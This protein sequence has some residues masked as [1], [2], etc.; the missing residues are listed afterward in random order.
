MGKELI[1]DQD[2]KSPIAEIFRTLRTNLQFMT[3]NQGLKTLLI[4]SGLP[5]EGKSWVSAN[6]AIAFAGEGKKVALIDSDMR[7]GRLHTIFE[8][9]RKPGLSNFLSGISE[10]KQKDDISDYFK[11]T[12]I[13]NLFIMP[14]GDAVPNPSELLVSNKMTE[15]ITRLK[16]NFDI[17]IFDGTPILLV[18]DSLILARQLD[19]SLIVTS[20]K[21]TKM[22]DIEK[23]KKMIENVRGKIAG[24][25]I[26]KIP[27]TIKKYENTYYYGHHE[28]T[29]KQQKDNKIIKDQTEQNT[30][31]VEQVIQKEIKEFM[32]KQENSKDNLLEDEEQRLEDD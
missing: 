2:P 32:Q 19:S 10:L 12:M 11:K 14:A 23:I 28:E 21:T 26:N 9:D 16:N 6:L 30:V 31:D 1:I 25:V 3:S 29:K 22:G 5:G 20:Y 13:E 7:K 24:V 15:L 17:I 27:I 18:T 4:T 8:I